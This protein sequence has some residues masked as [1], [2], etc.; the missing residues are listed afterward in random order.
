MLFR[1]DPSKI[2]IAIGYGFFLEMT[3]SE[4]VKFID[5]K[6]KHLNNK[7]E[8]MTNDVNSIKANIKLV[9]EVSV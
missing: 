2:C 5:K 8:S 7:V 3:L 6:T 4:A 9:L 1:E